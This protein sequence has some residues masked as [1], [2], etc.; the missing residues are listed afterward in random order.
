MSAPHIGRVIKLDF[1]TYRDEYTDVEVTRLSDGI[2]HT[3]HIYFTRNSMDRKGEKLLC[4]SNRTGWWQLYIINLKEMTMMQLT[5]DANVGACCLS[6]DGRKAYYWDGR[7]LKSVD[8]ETLER[9]IFFAVPENFHPVDMSISLDGRFLAFGYSE[10]VNLSTASGIIYS[11]M[12]ET[13]YRR[14]RSL[15]LRLDVSK[16]EV[17]PLWGECE[18]ISHININPV[19]P[20]EVLFCHEGPWHLVQRMWIVKASTHEVYPLL[21]QKRYLERAGH[22]FFTN[23]GRVVV[24]FA[25]R[26][27]PSSTDWTSYDVFLNTDGSNIKMFKYRYLAPAHIKSRDDEKVSVGDR[28]F[29]DPSFKDGAAFLGLIIYEDEEAIVKPLCRHGTSWLTQNSHPH[30]IFTPDYKGVIF[31]SDREG[32]CNIYLAHIEGIV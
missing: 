24:Q 4:V 32:E 10:I 13:L 20:D 31:T 3:V 19:N 30:P 27:T 22:E 6:Y 11:G 17:L 12:L 25:R 14:P 26:S 2:G 21:Q 7:F 29:P 23:K 28:A 5:N 9:D 8:T 15:V 18:W 16:R 1:K